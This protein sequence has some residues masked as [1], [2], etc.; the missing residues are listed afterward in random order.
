MCRCIKL[1]IVHDVAEGTLQ[2]CRGVGRQ[3]EQMHTYQK[4]WLGLSVAQNF[5]PIAAIVGDITP[6]DGVSDAEKHSL[7]SAAI[8]KMRDMLGTSVVAGETSWRA[9]CKYTCTCVV[10]TKSSNSPAGEEIEELWHEYEQ[11][12][13]PAAQLVKDFDKVLRLPSCA[14]PLLVP[15]HV[16][17]D[18]QHCSVEALF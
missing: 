6:H 15:K 7:E 1:A 5:A 12:Q 4:Q 2:C 17:V 14:A 3:N 10:G 9:Q 18:R 8:Q 11:G 16:Q 13:T